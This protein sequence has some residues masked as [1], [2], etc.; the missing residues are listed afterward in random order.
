MAVVTKYAASANDPSA[1]ALPPAVLAEA[2]DRTIHV[3]AVAITSGDSIGSKY[4]LGRIGSGDVPR[5]GS[6]SLKHG[7]VTSVNSAD[8]GLY[9]DGT[10]VNANLF[11]A[12][13]D[14]SS[15]GTKDPFAAIVVG[16]VGKRIWELL[17]LANDPGKIYDIV[18]TIN[19]AAT[20][21]ASVGG[22]INYSKK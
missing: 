4:V 20:A 9:K 8:I 22:H 1:S 11:A 5:A 12:A 3:P 16:T 7:A 15:A 13:L 19:V 18:L 21:T 6:A 2:R 10:V 17:G 14:I